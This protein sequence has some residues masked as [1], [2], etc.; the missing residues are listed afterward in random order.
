MKTYTFDVSVD[1][2]IQNISIDADSESEAMDKLNS[3]DLSDLVSDGYVKDF[4][5]SDIDMD[6]EYDEDEFVEDLDDEDLY[7]DSM[8]RPKYLLSFEVDN[9]LKW[10]SSSTE[11]VDEGIISEDSIYFDH[12]PTEF[13][14]EDLCESLTKDI[15]REFNELNDP[16]DP[17]NYYEGEVDLWFYNFKILD[18]S[19]DDADYIKL[20]YPKQQFTFLAE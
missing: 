11:C 12:V 20:D 7:R 10:C 17:Y 3:M 8:Q 1:A 18:L 16:R 15:A 19:S 13:E 14:I 4:A 9:S 2:W 6:V 5:I